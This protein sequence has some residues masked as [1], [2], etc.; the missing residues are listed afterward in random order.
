MFKR[1][2][3]DG[4]KWSAKWYFGSFSTAIATVFFFSKYLEFD[5]IRSIRYGVALFIVSFLV[6]TIIQYVKL[7]DQLETRIEEKDQQIEILNSKKEKK[8]QLGVSSFYGESIIILKEIFSNF[9]FLRKQEAIERKQMMTCLIYLCNGLKELFEKRFNNNYSVC[10]KV[11]GPDSDL[12]NL[13]VY[14]E[15]VTLCRDEKSYR[16]RS[17]P[18][19]VKHNI[20]DNTCFNEIFHN[21]DNP[22]RSHYL[23]N[24]LVEDKYYKNSS[25]NIYGELPNSCQTTEDRRRSWTLPYK[26]ELVVPITPVTTGTNV[27][28]KKQF[29][30]YLCVDCNEIDSFHNKYDIEMLK[31]VA[32]GIFDIIKYT[33]KKQ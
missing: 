8:K 14:A 17:V 16:R 2:L 10:I 1:A 11:L 5:F 3:I 18:N 30:G 29:L 9:H 6:K 7:I 23:N 24:D 31:G 33:Y 15:V 28:R 25:Y 13:T 21:I 20:F 19:G 27:E 12:E 26:S 22:D 4:F 32:D